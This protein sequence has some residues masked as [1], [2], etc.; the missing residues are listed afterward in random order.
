MRDA[1]RAPGIARAALIVLTISAAGVGLL[2]SF[3]PRAFYDDFPFVTQW[4]DLLPP[5]NEHL[6][7]DVGGLQLGFAVVLAWAAWTLQRELVRAACAGWAL[8]SLLH[9]VFHITNL[10]N[11]SAADAVAEMVSLGLVLVL[12]AFAVHGVGD[13]T[14]E[15]SGVAAG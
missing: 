6:V 15:P 10:E 12:P 11:F 14:R 2:A 5:Y 7:T 9:F 4:V 3:A 1:V 13:K 8:F